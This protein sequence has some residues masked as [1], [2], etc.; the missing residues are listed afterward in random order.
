MSE[1]RF[2]VAESSGYPIVRKGNEL[3]GAK[4][5][6]EYM[7]QDRAYCHRVVWTSA[8]DKRVNVGVR[9]NRRVLS[10]REAAA[11]VCK[12]LNDHGTRFAIRAPRPRDEQGRFA[13]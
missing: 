4:W 13:G 9:G 2:I 11:E 12:R 8:G 1:P 3:V 5:V 10:D 7:V 6:T